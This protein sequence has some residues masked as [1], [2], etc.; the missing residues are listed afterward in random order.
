MSRGMMGNLTPRHPAPSWSPSPP[1][2]PMGRCGGPG[3]SPAGP[4]ALAEVLK[5]GACRGGSAGAPGCQAAVGTQQQGSGGVTVSVPVLRG[6]GR[7][8][9]L[10]QALI[11]QPTGGLTALGSCSVPRL[12]AP[13]RGPRPSCAS[14][15]ALLRPWGQRGRRC[16][17]TQGS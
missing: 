15:A 2:G 8:P 1:R 10:R 17:R 7:S 5:P 3:S 6:A 9:S 13:G 14:P 11:P 12:G 16:S 4:R